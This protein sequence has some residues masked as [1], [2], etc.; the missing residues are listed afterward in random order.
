MRVGPAAGGPAVEAPPLAASV[1][2]R[3]TAPRAASP[4]P[5]E[6]TGSSDLAP[7]VPT[8]SGIVIDAETLAQEVRSVDQARAALAAGRAAA[9]LT[10]LDEYER[11]YSKR[12]FAPEALYLRMEALVSL[13][14]N[15]EARAVAERLLA[16][17]PMSPQGARAREVLSHHR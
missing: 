9:A 12:R 3:A 8:D 2:D 6:S 14:R 7:G 4:A 17:Y 11:R 5:V 15:T 16:R 13:E 1:A 10:A